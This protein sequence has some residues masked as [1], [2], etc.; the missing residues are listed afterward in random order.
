[1][2]G[3]SNQHFNLILILIE[4]NQ[5]LVSNHNTGFTKF[6]KLWLSLPILLKLDS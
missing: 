1:M 4:E 3:R 2:V 6:D 5:V